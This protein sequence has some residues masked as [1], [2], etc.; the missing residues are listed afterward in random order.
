M[1][2]TCILCEA[3]DVDIQACA[4]RTFARARGARACMR[5]HITYALL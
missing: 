5:A 4:D 3:T 2:Y 1:A